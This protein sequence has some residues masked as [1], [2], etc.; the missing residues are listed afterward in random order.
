MSVHTSFPQISSRFARFLCA[1]REQ[2]GPCSRSVCALLLMHQ[3]QICVH[4]L[5]QCNAS[6]YFFRASEHRCEGGCLRALHAAAAR[7][8][9]SVRSGRSRLQ[10]RPQPCGNLLQ[11]CHCRRR[12]CRPHL[13]AAGPDLQAMSPVQA[14]AA[15][16]QEIWSTLPSPAASVWSSTARTRTLALDAAS[17]ASV[18]SGVQVRDVAMCAPPLGRRVRERGL[19]G[20]RDASG[21][22]GSA[23]QQPGAGRL[24]T[25]GYVA[26]VIKRGDSRFVLDS[27]NI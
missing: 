12:R 26:G 18:S 9:P 2:V 1:S 15:D 21:A 24:V 3:F 11:R 14:T 13:A 19:C 10:H 5:P 25:E 20:L 7:P 23:P 8:H 16:L 17:T 27:R 22:H 4:Q 6:N